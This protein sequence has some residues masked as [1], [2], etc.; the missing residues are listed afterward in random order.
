MVHRETPTREKILA[1]EFI[2]DGWGLAKIGK[3]NQLTMG[4]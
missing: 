1:G 4:E 3:W 2:G